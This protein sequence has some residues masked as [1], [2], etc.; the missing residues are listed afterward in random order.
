[1]ALAVLPDGRIAAGCADETLRLWD[2]V[3]P[4]DSVVIKGH[5]MAVLLT[6]LP[7]G[8]IALGSPNYF[9]RLL[10]PAHPGEPLD[11][12]YSEAS[13]SLDPLELGPK[14]NAWALLRDGRIAFGASDHTVCLWDPA[15]PAERSILEGHAGGVNTLAVLPDGR[16]AS[17]SDDSTVRL[18]D[19]AHRCEPLVFEGHS[20]SVQALAVLPDG[21]IASG[22]KDHTV[23]LWDPT[24]K[25]ATAVF[26][27]D[28]AINCIVASAAGLIVAGCADGAV[29]FLRQ[30][31]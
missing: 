30:V 7:D 18:W 10:D 21:R 4:A 12:K 11:F 31:G 8:R 3:R 2:L 15:R 14:L 13:S 5:L 22:S 23:R 17:G 19:P 25:R 28:A 24:G 20:A 29:H 16:I 6:A 27:A 9:V 26:V 1:M